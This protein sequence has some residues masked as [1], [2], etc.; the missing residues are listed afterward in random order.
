MSFL[1]AICAAH[2]EDVDCTFALGDFMDSVAGDKAAALTFY[3]RVLTLQPTHIMA[4]NNEGAIFVER[5][6]L[7]KA[8]ELFTRA[9]ALA[10][11]Y[12]AYNL[13]CVSA[14]E[15]KGEEC[16]AWLHRVIESGGLS[17]EQ[18]AAQA[19]ADSDFDNVR[20]ERWFVQELQ[21]M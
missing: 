20:G 7:Q 21:G 2:P 4:L 16:R 3:D 1:H 13:A 17:V 6:E 14:L 9:D 15:S 12:C 18:L 10:P 5:G 11:G 19:R 8:R